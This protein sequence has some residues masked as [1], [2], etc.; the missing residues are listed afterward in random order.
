MPEHWLAVAEV[1]TNLTTLMQGYI[2]N[3]RSTPGTPQTND[4]AVEI[5]KTANKR[6]PAKK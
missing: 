2:A 1:A 5:F 4:V 6:N 3:G